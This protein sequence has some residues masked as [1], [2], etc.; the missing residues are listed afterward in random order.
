M[1]KIICVAFYIIE[2]NFN[3]LI[4]FKTIIQ[5]N[6]KLLVI[7][8]ILLQILY[9]TF[10][11]LQMKLRYGDPNLEQGDE[12]SVGQFL[13]SVK[14]PDPISPPMQSCNLWSIILI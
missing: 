7:S 10:H 6:M 4:Y 8:F 9:L 12:P 5:N 3:F 11:Y 13:Q 14:P 2:I 1:S